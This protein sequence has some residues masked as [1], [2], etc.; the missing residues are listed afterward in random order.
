MAA[1][2]RS[3]RFG[4]LSQDGV[5][6]A[7]DL[8]NNRSVVTKASSDQKDSPG[9]KRV[10]LILILLVVV[11]VPLI[12]IFL[13]LYYFSQISPAVRMPGFED[14]ET[15]E[16]LKPSEL[17]ENKGLY[18]D[19]RL[20]IL[21]K[22]GMA[23]IVCDRRECL[24]EDSCCGCPTERDLVLTDADK[25][26]FKES[27]WR[28]KLAGLESKP[29]CQR[30]T[31]SCDYECPGWEMGGVYQVGGQFYAEAPPMGSAW[32]LYTDAFFEVENYFL[33][34]STGWWDL[35]GTIAAGVAELIG[36]LKS[37]G[38]QFVLQ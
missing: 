10:L 26:I 36:G 9:K 38:G 37:A 30:I 19:T 5:A 16:F 12:L 4:R 23:P 8:L 33:V 11:V 3:G 24:P 21:G 28:L 13:Q 32:R 27:V 20:V 2:D 25:I 7:D 14:S 22:V 17:L 31:G 1:E 15:G 29:F 35:P 34:K 6:K 18:K